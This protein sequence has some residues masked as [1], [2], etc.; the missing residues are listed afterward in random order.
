M[1]RVIFTTVQ[2]N[3]EVSKMLEVTL[4]SF[5]LF[6]SNF[7]FKVYCLDNSKEQFEN[8]FKRFNFENLEFINFKD[9]TKWNSFLERVKRNDLTEIERSNIFENKDELYVFDTSVCISKLEIVD[10]LLEK[11]DVVIMSDIDVVYIDALEDFLET[12]L[13]SGNFIAGTREYIGDCNFYVNTGFV[14]FNSSKCSKNIFDSSIE[15]LNTNRIKETYKR[16]IMYFEQDL[17]S[18]ITDSKFEI[19]E[20]ICPVIDG[21]TRKLDKKFF[22]IHYAGK[23]F[24]PW[25]DEICRKDFDKS[26]FTHS[27]IEYKEFYKKVANLFDVDIDVKIA[28]LPTN[29]KTIVYKKLMHIFLQKVYS[30]FSQNNSS[31]SFVA[32]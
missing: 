2:Y 21:D 1:K 22:M 24:K 32:K 28:T 17:L 29:Y 30:K 25:I 20:I 7:D 19:K 31:S 18:L 3:E 23:E 13:K 14:I 10:L 26:M 9:G 27:L 6:N 12:F 4:K 16:Q 11:Y 5:Y 8:E 15:V